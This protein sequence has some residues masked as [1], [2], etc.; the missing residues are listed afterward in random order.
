MLWH[1]QE[2]LIRT[3]HGGMQIFVGELMYANFCSVRQI[4]IL[5]VL[6]QFRIFS[7][8]TKVLVLMPLII[9]CRSSP[10]FSSSNAHCKFY[11]LH[12]VSTWLLI[13]CAC[14]DVCPRPFHLFPCG[15]PKRG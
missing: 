9:M 14:S 11:L 15:A 12:D 8:G 7:M 4:P 10:L 6:V 2:T 5:L 1:P 13:A 3:I